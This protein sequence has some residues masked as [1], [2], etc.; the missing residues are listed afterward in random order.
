M[1][2]AT[3]IESYRHSGQLSSFL[4]KAVIIKNNSRQANHQTIDQSGSRAFLGSRIV[5]QIP[6]QGHLGFDAWFDST[7]LPVSV[8]P[9]NGRGVAHPI[10]E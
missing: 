8:N 10:T 1:R 5:C 3:L 2:K 7:V 6:Q 4:K 9:R